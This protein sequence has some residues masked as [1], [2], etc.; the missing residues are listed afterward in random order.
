VCD[1]WEFGMVFKEAV[2]SF[3]TQIFAAAVGMNFEASIQQVRDT[4]IKEQTCN[5]VQKILARI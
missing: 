1:F 4:N 2:Q 3:I 5:L